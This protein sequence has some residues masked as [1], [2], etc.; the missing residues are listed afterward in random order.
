MGR[1]GSQNMDGWIAR[2]GAGRG[3]GPIIYLVTYLS[4]TGPNMRVSYRVNKTKAT[5]WLL[6]KRLL[7]IIS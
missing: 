7:F 5:V 2:L 4:P 6:S 3:A 1:T